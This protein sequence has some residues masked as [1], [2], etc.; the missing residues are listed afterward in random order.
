VIHGDGTNVDLLIEEGLRTTDAFIAVTGNSE[1]NILACM[2][3]KNEGVRH[4]IAEIENLDFINLAKRM[5]I[6]TIINKKLIAAGHIY[7]YT[8]K[9]SVA[10]MKYLATTKA[11]VLEFIVSPKSKI[12]AHPLCET[13]FPEN[14][15]IGGLIRGGNGYIAHGDMWIQPGDHVVVITLPSAIGEVNKFFV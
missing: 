7:R 2:L 10:M 5:G 4:T 8:L 14:A 6:D 15:I 1:T 9:S 12:I 3:A 11:E 13:H